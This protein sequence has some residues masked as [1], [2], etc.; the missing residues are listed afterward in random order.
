VSVALVD[1]STGIKAVMFAQQGNNYLHFNL[2]EVL[3]APGD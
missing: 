1:I 3:G 2:S